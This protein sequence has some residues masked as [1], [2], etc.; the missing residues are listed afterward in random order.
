LTQA[1]VLS[2]VNAMIRRTGLETAD[3]SFDSIATPQETDGQWADVEPDDPPPTVVEETPERPI[4]KKKSVSGVVKGRK[5]LS[6]HSVP[7]W[8]RDAGTAMSAPPR[9]SSL[10][11]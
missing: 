3:A 6:R 5:D 8:R 10:Q 4:T 9:P 7:Q 1:E 11:L 2:E